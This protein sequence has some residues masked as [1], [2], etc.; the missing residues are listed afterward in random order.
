MNGSLIILRKVLTKPIGNEFSKDSQTA[1]WQVQL[2]T[3]TSGSEARSQLKWVASASA[4]ICRCQQPL[5]AR[6]D[7]RPCK[8]EECQRGFGANCRP[9][10]HRTEFPSKLHQI[11]L[12]R[13]PLRYT[14]F[15]ALVQGSNGTRSFCCKSIDRNVAQA[16]K[17]CRMRRAATTHSRSRNGDREFRNETA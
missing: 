9:D 14:I 8:N 5:R 1:S 11:E 3:N 6:C 10:E 2:V 7:D 15:C 4:S 13:R 12:C 17:E 16:K